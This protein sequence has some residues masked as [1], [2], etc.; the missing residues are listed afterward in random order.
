MVIA[1]ID[2]QNRK[3]VQLKQG[4]EL[5][6]QRDNPEE[7]AEEFDRFGEVAIIDLDAAMGTRPFGAPGSNT[8]MIKS[9]LRKAECRVGGGIRTPEQAKELLSNGAKKIIISSSAFRNPAKKNTGIGG[10]EFGVN[11][12][13]LG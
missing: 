6:L 5:L 7:L 9:L 4:E 11:L 13:F 3:V 12:P 8:E 10:G 1:S 2:I